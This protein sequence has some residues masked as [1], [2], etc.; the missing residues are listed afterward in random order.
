[1]YSRVCVFVGMYCVYDAGR[2]LEASG[3]VDGK[4]KL[5]AR[6]MI[7]VVL[8]SKSGFR[9]LPQYLGGGGTCDWGQLVVICGDSRDQPGF[10]GP[11]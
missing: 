3:S 5:Q 6:M 8:K 7:A 10:L 11:I 1:M 4:L 2:C 9:F